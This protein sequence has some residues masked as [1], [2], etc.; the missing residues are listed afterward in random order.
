MLII[1]NPD[2]S[3]PTDETPNIDNSK[4]DNDNSDQV[5]LKTPATGL[6]NKVVFYGNILLLMLLM[7]LGLRN[8]K[9]KNI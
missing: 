3:V 6:Q 7:Y 4:V 5:K 9:V 8:K 1:P 2:V